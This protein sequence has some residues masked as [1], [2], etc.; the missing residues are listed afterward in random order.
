MAEVSKA[1]YRGKAALRITDGTMEA[2]VVPELS[3]RIVRFGPVG[4]D[5][6]L[7]TPPESKVFGPKDWQNWGGDKTWPALQSEWGIFSPTGVWPPHPTWDGLPHKGEILPGGKIRT[8]GP[9][10]AGYGVRSVREIGFDPDGALTVETTFTKEKGPPVITAI[11]HVTQIKPPEA[12][13]L[14]LS[15]ESTYSGGFHWFGGKTPPESRT[16]N[17]SKT[18]LEF[19]PTLG[20]YELGADVPVVA[21]AIVRKGQAFVQRA[22]KIAGGEYPEGAPGNG[23]PITVYNGGDPDPAL[24]YV[25]VETMSPLVTLKPG[26]RLT[27]KVRWTAH[28]LA[29]GD[30]REVV[31]RL[32]RAR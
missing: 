8:V 16:R 12:V 7:W 26:Q 30:L 9:V 4:G 5:N 27:H 17:V 31:E 32:L 23:F 2:L 18:L 24:S 20:G 10:M 6:W 11:W 28:L 19:A 15:P 13:Y 22:E 1:T 21:A 14:P 25:E 29:A 3:G